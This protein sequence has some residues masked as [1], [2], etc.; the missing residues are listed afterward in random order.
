MEPSFLHQKGTR[1]DQS[2]TPA[3]K[4]RCF[5]ATGLNI[6]GRIGYDLFNSDPPVEDWKPFAEKLATLKDSKGDSG[7]NKSN[8]LWRDIYALGK[9]KKG[10]DKWNVATQRGP[11]TRA[12]A[13]VCEA[14]GLDPEP[15]GRR[16]ETVMLSR[17]QKAMLLFQPV[18]KGC[19]S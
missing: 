16:P 18:S 15:N 12:V 4:T 11:M 9:D 19:V 17:P 13:R 8:D 2:P 7:W 10:E 3:R 1:H 14:I 6:I 5:S